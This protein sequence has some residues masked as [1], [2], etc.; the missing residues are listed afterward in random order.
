MGSS[1]RA[2][3][4]GRLA[5][6]PSRPPPGSAT[7]CLRTP[8]FLRALAVS[9]S[10]AGCATLACPGRPSCGAS[11]VWH[12]PSAPPTCCAAAAAYSLHDRSCSTFKAVGLAT[13]R[14]PP[15]RRRHHS[16]SSSTCGAA[17]PRPPPR[18]RLGGSAPP[19]AVTPSLRAGLL[20]P[21]RKRGVLVDHDQVL[22]VLIDVV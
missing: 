5:T 9:C 11:A 3:E 22:E 4:L 6:G 18:R 16:R 20:H 21:R 8:F 12:A 10:S 14:L 15:P 19:N 7:C 13:A 2:E 1:S 17:A